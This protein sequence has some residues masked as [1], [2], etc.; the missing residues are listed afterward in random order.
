MNISE[1]LRGVPLLSKDGQSNVLSP[2]DDG[3]VLTNAVI[4]K[5]PASWTLRGCRLS[6]VAVGVVSAE[7]DDSWWYYHEQMGHYRELMDVKHENLNVDWYHRGDTVTVSIDE[8]GTLTVEYQSDSGGY[9]TASICDLP[10]PVIPA[11][12]FNK[13]SRQFGDY[14]VEVSW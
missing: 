11:V 8:Q 10:F 4:H 12:N 2:C 6:E 13:T 3:P 1:K 7:G 5:G 9:A 14:G